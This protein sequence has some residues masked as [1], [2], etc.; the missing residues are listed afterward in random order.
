MARAPDADNAHSG[1]E[2]QFLRCFDRTIVIFMN[3]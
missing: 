3:L 2:R 1:P